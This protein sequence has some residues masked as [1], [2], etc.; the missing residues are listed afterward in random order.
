MIT[1]PNPKKEQECTLKFRAYRKQYKLPFYLVAD[2]EAFLTP[3]ESQDQTAT[4]VVNE[5]QISGFACHRVTHIDDY[6]TPPTVYSGNDVMGT[7]YEH[8]MKE[9]S[10]ISNILGVEVPMSPLTP[11]QITNY[12]QATHCGNCDEP[13]SCD[14]SP[15]VHHHCHVTGNYLFA[16]CVRCNLQLKHNKRQSVRKPKHPKTGTDEW[17]EWYQDVQELADGN[18]DLPGDDENTNE[19]HYVENFFLP[20]V[21]HNLKN[22][23]A[24]FII[25]HFDKKYVERRNGDN[26]VTSMSYHSIQKNTSCSKSDMCGFWPRANFCPPHWTISFRRC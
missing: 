11:Q 25:K 3:S 9:V 22:Y 23:D 13:F 24:H 14:K 2:F 21:F 26:K 1:Y 17:E 8:I 10:Q 15:K 18:F 20:V 16:S 6:K 12:D 7:F 5:H 4:V 19:Q